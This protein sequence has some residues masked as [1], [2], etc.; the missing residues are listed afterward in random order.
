MSKS[1]YFKFSCVI[2]A[3][4]YIRFASVFPCEHSICSLCAMR[5]RVKGRDYTCP[6]CKQESEFGIIYSA[7]STQG[8]LKPY[9]SFGCDTNNTDMPGI[10]NDETSRLL[11]ID[12]DEHYNDLVNIRS[13]LCPHNNCIVDGKQ[14][15]RFRNE[16]ELVIHINKTHKLTMCLLCLEK[17]SLF[18]S[19]LKLMNEFQLKKH[20]V[21]AGH[22][23][24][25]FCNIHVYDATNL[26]V[27]C[28]NEHFSC[29]LCPIQFQHRYYHKIRDLCHHFKDSHFMCEV[30]HPN[31]NA[32]SKNN[33]EFYVFQKKS[34]YI[35]HL[36]LFH[37]IQRQQSS[38]KLSF[39]IG[40]NTLANFIDLD[41]SQADPNNSS[42]SNSYVSNTISM[43]QDA[44]QPYMSTIPSNMR[45]AGKVTGSGTF[46]K[47][48]DE[49]ELQAA[50]DSVASSTK[51][52][53]GKNSSSSKP[54]IDD[55]SQFPALAPTTTSK[56][57]DIHPMSLI[58]AK[59]KVKTAQQ[60]ATE[61]ELKLSA[62]LEE[63]K[64][65]RNMALAEAFGVQRPVDIALPIESDV[66]VSTEFIKQH[67]VELR[68]PLFPPNLVTWGKLNNRDLLQ[69][70]KKWSDFLVDPK[71]TSL[72]MKPMDSLIRGYIHCLAKYYHLNSFE[73]DSEPKRYVSL[74]KQSDSMVPLAKLSG[75]LSIPQCD[76]TPSLKEKQEPYIYFIAKMHPNA[77]RSSAALPPSSINYQVISTVANLL[78]RLQIAIK[79]SDFAALTPS[80]IGL[81]C[82]GPSGVALQFASIVEASNL[83]N[84]ILT[85][86][87]T[88]V[89]IIEYFYVEP[90]FNTAT[91]MINDSSIP[92]EALSTTNSSVIEITHAIS[93]FC[94]HDVRTKKID[95]DEFIVAKRKPNK[96][97]DYTRDNNN[98]INNNSNSLSSISNNE[99]KGYNEM[100]RYSEAEAAQP[101]LGKLYKIKTVF[102]HLGDDSSDEKEESTEVAKNLN[103]SD[104]ASNN[105][106]PMSDSW[107]CSACTFINEYTSFQFSLSI[108][109]MC[110]SSR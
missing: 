1:V 6:L 8:E 14:I 43:A 80:I 17:T 23:I 100:P 64:K 85:S 107:T 28:R 10:R 60:I 34:D 20:N 98:N 104:I 54:I 18:V 89:S 27:H 19:E 59:P 71:G 5:L 35:E 48:Q 69:L 32:I 106:E 38:I 41:M 73:Y 51:T 82:Y 62:E 40:S 74:V 37:G 95:P 57:T 87:T 75:A 11:F 72:N 66:L 86:P 47:G 68:R 70:E 9:F 93:E 91:P 36:S 16:K 13:F 30:C 24:C 94:L 25:Q 103:M 31:I 39:T 63:R 2:C 97:S 61:N 76:I 22:P 109:Q 50:L 65:K 12:C 83:L 81:S 33:T 3:N 58:N 7:A 79:D 110:E 99:S 15:S 88:T 90:A 96:K 52:N 56:K 49:D 21:A 46:V 92:A 102:S 84:F 77:Y 78:K 101:G 105:I 44:I 53:R 55:Q 108:C 29:H 67:T 26:Y 45:I 4:D 42:S